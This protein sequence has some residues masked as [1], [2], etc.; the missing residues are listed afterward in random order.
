MCR[1]W[2]PLIIANK[3]DNTAIWLI[4]STR[5]DRQSQSI[6]TTILDDRYIEMRES[7]SFQRSG[8][9]A[10]SPAHQIYLEKVRQ[11]LYSLFVIMISTPMSNEIISTSNLKH[12]QIFISW[13]S[14]V[15]FNLRNL[16]N[17]YSFSLCSDSFHMV[18]I[19]FNGVE[20]FVGKNC[21]QR[22]RIKMHIE[23]VLRTTFLH[24]QCYFNG[25]VI[26]SLIIA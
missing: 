17:S 19:Q 14:T 25:G 8:F 21:V 24:G 2:T 16:S 22:G 18:L 9:T 26:T 23:K 1:Q 3:V 13:G 5:L 7:Q 15:L 20:K 6:S 11:T 10:C 4:I 12:S